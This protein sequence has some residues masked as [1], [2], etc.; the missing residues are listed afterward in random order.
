VV[1]F[2]DCFQ[3]RK[4]ATAGD[5]DGDCDLRVAMGRSF[6]CEFEQKE[7]T[8]VSSGGGETFQ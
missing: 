3:M 1:N 4:R 2:L 6:G 5:A 7:D 8:S